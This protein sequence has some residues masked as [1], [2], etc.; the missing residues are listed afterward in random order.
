MLQNTA[1]FEYLPLST[2]EPFTSAFHWKCPFQGQQWPP[3]CYNKFIGHASPFPALLYHW[4][5]LTAPSPLKHL[6][7]FRHPALSWFFLIPLQPFSVFASSSSCPWFL[8]TGTFL[9]QSLT[10]LFFLSPSLLT[11]WVMSYSFLV[12]NAICQWTSLSSHLLRGHLMAS[13]QAQPGCL[14]LGRCL[15]PDASETEPLLLPAPAPVWSS[16][17]FWLASPPFEWLRPQHL[18]SPLTSCPP[19]SHIQSVSKLSGLCFRRARVRASHALA[20]WT[21]PPEDLAWMMAVV[22][23]LDLQFDLSRAVKRSH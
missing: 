18:E 17:V 20:C 11:L 4:T 14:C 9:L 21:T 13:W 8:N 16:P 5:K 7:G 6:L 10:P 15:K 19:M 2:Y 3:L 1:S 22:S 23:H 12:L